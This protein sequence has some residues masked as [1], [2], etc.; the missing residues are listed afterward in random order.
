VKFGLAYRSDMILVAE[1]TIAPRIPICRFDNVNAE[2]NVLNR[3]DQRNDF[4]PPTPPLTTSSTH[5]AI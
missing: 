2:F 1:R 5:S 3:L 4:C